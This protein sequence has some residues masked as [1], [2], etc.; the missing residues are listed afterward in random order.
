MPSTLRLRKNISKLAGGGA[1]A[2][3]GEWDPII[4]WYAKAV[5]AMRPKSIDDP[6]SWRYQAAIHGFDASE[7]PLQPGERALP[8]N[9]G[10]PWGQCQHGGWYFLPWHRMYLAYF[11]RI[12][13]AT[14]AQLGGPADWALPYWNYCDN[15]NPD[16]TRIPFAFRSPTLVDGSPNPLRIPQRVRGNSG[17]P[18]VAPP[19]AVAYAMFLLAPRFVG[20]NT[21]PDFGFGGPPTDWHHPPGAAGELEN[22]PHNL[23]HSQIN[24]YMGDFNT[25]ALDPIFWLHHCN[26]DRMWAIW[27]KRAVGNTDPTD[28]AWLTKLSFSWQDGSGNMVT[29]TPSQVVE[30]TASPLSYDY[31]DTQDPFAA[32]PP[33]PALVARNIEAMEPIPPHPPE[34]VGATDRPV[35]LSGQSTTVQLQLSQPTGPA[36]AAAVGVPKHVFLELENITGGKTHLN[37]RVFVNLPPDA[38]PDTHEEYSAGILS[39]FG[40]AEASRPNARH[41]GTGLHYRLSIGGLIAR[42]QAANEWDANR[43]RITLVPLGPDADEP[44]PGFEFVREG[45]PL[46]VGRISLYYT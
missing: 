21:G 3:A 28:P 41:P 22:V 11:E 6:T 14:I 26:I 24:G 42:L 46:Q 23:I 25:A 8:T 4:A 37:Y 36:R 35:V 17:K 19:S 10:D 15:T 12:V 30:T 1:N 16:A 44:E 43:V 29:V 18:V 33:S 40:V 32:A 2:P 9:Q 27:R 5:A 39:T 20:G 34:M 7:T 13:A 45:A 38:D 31:D